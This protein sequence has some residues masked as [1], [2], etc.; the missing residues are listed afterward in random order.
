MAKTR[1]GKDTPPR[2][3]PPKVQYC[4]YV[5][6]TDDEHTR[7]VS[8]LGARKTEDM[9]ERLDTYIGQIG[10]AKARKYKS[11]YDTILNWYRKDSDSDKSAITLNPVVSAS[12]AGILSWAQRERE[13]LNKEAG[14]MA[15]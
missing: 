1:G 3:T 13:R 2:P 6:L 14:E 9:I 7:L 10:T 15:S 8:R 4:R 11:H 12:S 5:F